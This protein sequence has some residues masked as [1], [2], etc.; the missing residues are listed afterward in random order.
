MRTRMIIR[1]ILTFVILLSQTPIVYAQNAKCLIEKSQMLINNE[2]YKE[3][4]MILIGI[5]EE[6]ISEYGDTCLMLYNYGKGA[7]LYFMDKYEEAI[8]FL[9]KGLTYREKMPHEDCDYLEMLYR[10]GVC[11]KKLGDYNNAEE[12]F[13]RTILKSNY[14]NLNCTIRNQT[15][16]EMAELY[17]LMGKPKFADICTSRIESEMR[18]KNV[19]NLDAQLDGLWD[20]Y[21]VH[22]KMGKVDE[23]LSDLKKM[24]H[25]V[26]ENK[27]KTNIDYLEYS[28][29]LGTNLRYSY[30]RPQEAASVHKEMIEIGKQFRTYQYIVLSAYLDYLRYLSENNKVDSIEHILPAAIKYYNETED[31]RDEIVN[32]YEIVGNGLCDAKNFEEGVKYL[33]KKWNDK[34]AQ[35]IKALDYL[36]YY[37][38]VLKNNPEKALSF[39]KRSEEIINGGHKVIESTKI[40]ILQYLV[41]INQRLGNNQEAK[42]YSKI[43]EPLILSTG[44]NQKYLSYLISWSMECANSGNNEQCSELVSKINERMNNLSI[45]DKIRAYNQMAF[46]CIKTNNFDKAIDYATKGISLTKEGKGEESMAIEFLYHNLGRAYMLKGVYTKA[47][48]ALNKSKELQLKRKGEVMKRTADYIKECESK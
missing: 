48:S 9:K 3:A 33:E 23:C 5:N 41:E 6:Q 45:K 16:G 32:I 26:E 30:E 35:S 1:P 22:E 7:C 17:S 25:L 2:K 20:L 14:F 10:I 28:Y 4:E 21:K 38:F 27:G 37:Y 29:I 42:R 13:R 19:N 8:P 12:Y 44:D 39:A 18:I 15:Y 40:N 11:Y 24:R 31:K 43:I 47:L 36:T 46:V 34:T